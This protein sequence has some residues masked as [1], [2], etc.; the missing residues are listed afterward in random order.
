MKRLLPLSM[1]IA[2][3]AVAVM[4]HRVSTA[5]EKQDMPRASGVKGLHFHGVPQKVN[6]RNAHSPLR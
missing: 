1:V 3:L 6:P 2:T 4:G 5:Q